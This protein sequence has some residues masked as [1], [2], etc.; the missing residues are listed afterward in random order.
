MPVVKAADIMPVTMAALRYGGS[1]GIA[2]LTRCTAARI[3]NLPEHS[4]L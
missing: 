1:L 4:A 3:V 2:N